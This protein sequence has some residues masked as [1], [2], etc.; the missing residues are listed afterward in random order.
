VKKNGR[1]KWVP[2]PV[3]LELES[4]KEQRGLLKDAEA[5]KEMAGYSKVGREIERI[6]RF[7]LG[8]RRK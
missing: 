7:G 4:V 8:G 2:E 1:P 3:L 6:M 5:F